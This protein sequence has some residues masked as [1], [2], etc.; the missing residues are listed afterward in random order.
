MFWIG[1][2]VGL[3]VGVLAG[4]CVGSLLSAASSRDDLLAAAR[5]LEEKTKPS[6]LTSEPQES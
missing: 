6:P 4:I 3:L 5:A 1:A 2:L